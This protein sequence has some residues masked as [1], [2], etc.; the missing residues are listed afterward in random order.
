MVWS[1][2]EKPTPI[3]HL[4]PDQPGPAAGKWLRTGF[5]PQLSHQT[6]WVSSGCDVSNALCYFSCLVVCVGPE[7]LRAVYVVLSYPLMGMPLSSGDLITK[8]NDTQESIA[9]GKKKVLSNLMPKWS[10]Y[11][12]TG[13]IY[14]VMCNSE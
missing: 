6:Q 12:N 5:H 8:L 10:C 13:V 7:V 4:G 3:K 9:S 14:T 2:P 11:G 1:L